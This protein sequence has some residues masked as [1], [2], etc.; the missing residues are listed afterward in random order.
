MT[1][2]QNV[3][4]S[5]LGIAGGIVLSFYVGKWM[6]RRTWIRSGEE[7]R[8]MYKSGK[9]FFVFNATEFDIV[10][11]RT[12]QVLSEMNVKGERTANRLLKALRAFRKEISSKDRK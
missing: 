8:F 4:L 9:R 6:E 1:I 5:I 10:D 12:A 11:T 2:D 3:L 7:N